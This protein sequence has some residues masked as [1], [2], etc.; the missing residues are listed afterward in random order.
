MVKEERGGVVKIPQGEELNLVEKNR[1][2][3]GEIQTGGDLFRSV[4]E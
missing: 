2:A 1:G 3:N 4:G